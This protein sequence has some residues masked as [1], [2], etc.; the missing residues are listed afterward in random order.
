MLVSNHLEV[1]SVIISKTFCKDAINKP[2]TAAVTHTPHTSIQHPSHSQI[3]TYKKPYQ[4]PINQIN[5]PI[6]SAIKQSCEN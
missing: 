1:L 6:D 3:H 2:I 5:Q 4:L